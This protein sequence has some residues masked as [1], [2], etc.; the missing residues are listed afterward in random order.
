[1][2]LVAFFELQLPMLIPVPNKIGLPEDLRLG[3]LDCNLTAPE[4]LY[5]L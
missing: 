3:L 1:M 4:G 2:A 5:P